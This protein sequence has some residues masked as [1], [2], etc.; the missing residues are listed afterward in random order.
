MTTT[1]LTG[2]TALLAALA[3]TGCAPIGQPNGGNDDNGPDAGTTAKACDKP[4]VKTMNLTVTGNDSIGNLPNSCWHL[5]GTLTINGTASSL[6]KL[7]DLRQVKDLVITSGS[8]TSID[9]SEGLTVT[10]KLDIESSKLT[11]L[12]A[13]TLPDDSSCLTY[14]DSVTVTA[15]PSLTDLGGVAAMTCVSG[16]VKISNNVN[17]PSIR[18]DKAQRLEG[19]VEISYNNK[20]TQ[21]TMANVTSITGDLVVSNNALLSSFTTLANLKYMHGSVTIDSNP[22]LTTLPTAMQTAPAPTIESSL[23]ITNNPKLTELGAF[24]K[25]SGV[26]LL[27]NI[28]NNTT[29]DVCQAK[30]V[31]CCVYHPGTATL[32][33]NSGTSCA[34]RPYCI[35]N[36][37]NNCPYASVTN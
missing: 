32:H 27:I 14:L 1:R 34:V 12:A 16:A 29:L 11:S 26:N 6:A 10:R 5:D 7:G 9:M 25:L 4:I 37:S 33:G 31:G 19:G 15:N 13:I 28:S 18:L 35:A 36:T 3:V 23:T 30:A 17:L 22:M 2:T 24:T 20:L 8:L 21:L